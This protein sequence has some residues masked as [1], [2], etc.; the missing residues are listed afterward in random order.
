MLLLLWFGL[1]WV[2]QGREWL[3][4]PVRF[5]DASM[6]IRYVRHM[7]AGLGM[8]WNH[9][10]VHTYGQTSLLWT[11]TVWA[12]SFL[13]VALTKTMR[14]GS[15]GCSVAAITAMAWAV[16]RQAASAYMASGWRVLSLVALPLGAATMFAENASTG[17][18]TMLAATMGA[19]FLGATLGWQRGTVRAEVAGLAGLLLFLARPEAG[20]AVVAMPLLVWALMRG[21]AATGVA[22]LLG[23]FAAGVA[24][25]LA[26]CR[27]YFHTAFPLS[28]YMKSVHGYEGYAASWFPY[29]SLLVF[30]D[31]CKW[32][33]VGMILL[34]RK[35]EIRLVLCC[36]LPAAA[37]FCYLATVTQV[38]GFN[39]RYYVPYVPFFVV[40]ALLALDARI[41][42][43]CF[44]R[45][46]GWRVAAGALV[47]VCC[48]DLALPRIAGAMD[49]A[50]ARPLYTYDPVQL[51]YAGQGSPLRP[52]FSFSF[53]I[54][55]IDLLAA[56]LPKGATVASTDVGYLGEAAADADVIDLA[57][58]N[59][60]EI[61]MHGFS[62]DRLMARRPDLIWIPPAAYSYLCG[63]LLTN[64]TFRRDYDLYAGAANS[65][66]AVRRES[67]FR[68]AIDR[69][70]QRFWE[71][72]YPDKRMSDYLVQ[73]VSWSGQRHR[74]NQ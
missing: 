5:D 1:W 59:D 41:R 47:L 44:G 67:A 49:R 68:P 55:A 37:V 17:M 28:F 56:P 31:G 6:S 70:M 51:T 23:M 38:M 7:R 54:R 57:G 53:Y 10:G 15:W 13:P 22:S 61:G 21:V 52:N 45:M 73:A 18:E 62:A 14:L 40:P 4:G 26:L 64:G 63:T 50:L 34:V 72:F 3:R 42:D 69:Q 16:A 30:L 46:V 58:L 66:V 74:V 20:I 19:I 27:W 39:A 25:D 8:S 11:W 65:G 71:N 24:L 60:N 29:S 35:T 33:L 36:L 9:D 43:A 48:S 2:A 32:Y 12:M